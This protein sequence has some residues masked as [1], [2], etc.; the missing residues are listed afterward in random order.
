M[1]SATTPQLTL[2]INCRV[3]SSFRHFASWASDCG[4]LCRSGKSLIRSCCFRLIPIS[5]NG[6]TCTKNS[7]RRYVWASQKLNHFLVFQVTLP[8]VEKDLVSHDNTNWQGSYNRLVYL[9]VSP[10]FHWQNTFATIA[11]NPFRKNTWWQKCN[12]FTTISE[13]REN[14]S[15]EYLV[16]ETR[17]ALI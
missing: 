11:R 1:Y 12:N 4:E 5:G 10:N 14:W 9:S 7:G 15:W 2:I 6:L 8:F 16:S 3:S 17:G 13:T